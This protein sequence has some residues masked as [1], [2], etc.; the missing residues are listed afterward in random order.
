M[1]RKNSDS[2]GTTSFQFL[3]A[4]GIISVAVLLICYGFAVR[5][6]VHAKP[7]AA[8]SSDF[9]GC[10]EEEV[11][12]HLV[13]NHT[14][15]VLMVI[16]AWR[17]SFLVEPDSP[18]AFLRSSITSGRGVAFATTVQ[19]PTVTMPRIKALTSGMI[20]SFISLVTNF[21]ATANTEDNWVASAASMGK[22]IVFFGDDTWLRLFPDV[23]T[24]S[25][26][27]IS[28][29]V[30]DFTEV[31][32]NVT[33]HLDS[34]LNEGDWD[35]LILHYLGLDHIGHSLG[36]ISPQL[37]RKLREMDNIAERIFKTVS[38]RAPVLLVAMADHGMTSA[39][40]HG[41]GSES[42]SRVPMVFLHSG[43]E[44]KRGG[45][46]HELPTAQQVDLASTMP[47][48]LSTEIPSES[49]GL[50]LIPRL[51]EHWKLA[52]STIFSAA[53]QSAVHFSKFMED[54]S[55]QRLRIVAERTRCQE[56]KAY[57]A[58]VQSSQAAKISRQAQQ[59]IIKSQEQVLGWPVYIGLLLVVLVL[60]IC[61]LIFI[62]ISNG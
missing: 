39:G 29:F 60:Q 43:V 56:A 37:N 11:G 59:E 25:D 61:P 8:V 20:P 55:L 21:F 5:G 47:F 19:T 54:H 18:M 23:F 35:V 49:V 31:D 22:K 1:L 36:G 42:E 13:D 50:S 53:V 14:K 12:D 17:L 45:N 57:A 38:A 3:L 28:F 2:S 10:F 46:L 30:N 6:D 48:F 51:A 41:G 16:D 27:V 40:S 33:R 58:Y 52:D 44:I 34:K 15:V 62:V 9:R 4:S 24:V 26:G 32:N 7:V